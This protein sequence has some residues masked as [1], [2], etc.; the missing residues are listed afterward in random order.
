MCPSGVSQVDDDDDDND[1]DDD[2]ADGD[3]DDDD[4]D[5]GDIDDDDDWIVLKTLPQVAL[6]LSTFF[7]FSTKINLVHKYLFRILPKN[8]TWLWS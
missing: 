3:I 4:D 8:V 5:D 6:I 2:D 7:V 1:D